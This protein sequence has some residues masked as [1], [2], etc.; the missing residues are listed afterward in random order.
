MQL[1]A[2]FCAFQTVDGLIMFV[3]I[4]WT[5]VIMYAASQVPLR[6]ALVFQGAASSRCD[7]TSTQSNIASWLLAAK[8]RLDFRRYQTGIPYHF[9]NIKNQEAHVSRVS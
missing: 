2:T 4:A 3:H 8:E 5:K 9:P 7:P 1:K 6:A